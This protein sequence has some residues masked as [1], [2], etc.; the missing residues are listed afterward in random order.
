MYELRSKVA[1]GVVLGAL[2]PAMRALYF[3]LETTLRTTLLN[4]LIDPRVGELFV[5][6]GRIDQEWPLP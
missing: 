2:D 1:H 4:A 5:S 3:D 6:E